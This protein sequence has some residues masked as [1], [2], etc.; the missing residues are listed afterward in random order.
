[1]WHKLQRIAI[2]CLVIASVKAED[3]DADKLF[4]DMEVV[5]D[6]FEESPKELLKVTYENGLDVGGGREFTPTE[7]KDEPKVDWTAEP[8]AYY[9]LIMSTLDY[10]SRENPA[11]REWLHW[12]VVN[13][14]GTDIAKGDVLDPYVGPLTAKSSG[15][16][17]DVF[18]V[19]KQPGKQAFDEPV[20]TNTNVTGHEKFSSPKL[21]KKYNMELVAGNIFQARWDEYVPIIRRQFGILT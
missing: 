5:P 6:I 15:L 14:P 18:L 20:I 11:L 2:F 12:L 21:A 16:V 10:P 3:N 13:I 7:T 19:Y 4:R 9:T 8:D 17:R 1:M